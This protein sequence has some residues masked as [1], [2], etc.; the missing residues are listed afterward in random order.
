MTDTKRRH[1]AFR[2][3]RSLIFYTCFLIWP[4]AQFCVFYI[5]VNFN[6]FALAFKNIPDLLKPNEYTLT[7]DNFKNWFVSGSA[8]ADR[9]ARALKV[10]VKTYF[11]T[12][13]I[14][15]PL[16]LFFSYYIFKKLPGAM[17]FRV[18]L[19]MPSII[20]SIVL[21]TVF[22]YFTDFVLPDL[23]L[24][25]F[26]VTVNET[27]LSSTKTRYGT[28]MF[29]NIFVGFGTTVLL[30][31]N[32]M[33]SISPEVIE[34][35]ELDG[36]NTA[37]EFFRIVLPQTFST[38]SIFLVTGVTSIFTNEINNFSFFHYSMNPDT[39]TIGFLM[40]Y[41][42]QHAKKDVT[43]YPP[44]AALGLMCTAIAIPV[45]FFVR[46]LLDKFGPSED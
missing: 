18:M 19:F 1:R 42:M 41:K 17:T 22:I 23:S 39:T 11:I 30:Y 14:S 3:R 13:F 35:A 43:Q 26:N 37:Q 6:S 25:W 45:T 20:P 7:F 27:L 8:D 34:A 44:I 2:S 4:I 21:V 24:K 5:G 32:K 40:Y 9:L 10:S 29:Y 38:V 36:A 31:S 16:G 12:L 28:V 33:A 15:V 46:W